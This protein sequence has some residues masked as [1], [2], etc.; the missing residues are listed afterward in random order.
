MRLAG[1]AI[2]LAVVLGSGLGDAM[3]GHIEGQDVGY[4]K[5]HAPKPRVGGHAGIARV[6]TLSDRR[7]AAFAGRV[8]LYEG[9]SPHEVTYLVRVAAAAGAS[10]IVLTN[11]AG[12]LD[13]TYAPGD[14]M[15]VSDHINATG[16]S[17]FSG[18]SA[19]PFVVMADAYAR[20]LRDTA[21][22]ALP[23]GASLREGVY[24]GVRGPHFETRAECEA[25]RRL[26]ADAV[27]MSMVLE[28]IAA[29]ALGLAVLGISIITNVA[30]EVDDATHDDILD[31]AR[32]RAH[33]IPT[34]VEAILRR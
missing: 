2:D 5:L 19:A 16:A 1:G 9:R 12:A 26:G 21:R 22:T 13:R 3:V 10:T 18:S 15:L 33:V 30:G 11:A 20:E 27:G 25:L 4:G 6:G 8:H 14:V 7:V 29:R 34:I 17:P 23:D 31:A 24:A 28:V 32:A